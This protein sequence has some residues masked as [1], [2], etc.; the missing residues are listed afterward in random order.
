MLRVPHLAD[1]L[2]ENGGTGQ[3]KSHIADITFAWVSGKSI[4]EIAKSYF[5]GNETDS[6]T[7][8]CKAIYKNIVNTGTWGLS[9]LSRMAGLDFSNLS[10]SQRR[11]INV[12]PAMIYHGVQTEEAVL[13]RM[14]AAPRSVAENL[15]AEF[16]SNLG[17][18][19]SK[20]NASSARE[21]IK[22]L[23]DKD[24]DRIKPASS[25]LSGNDYKAI[26]ELLSGEQR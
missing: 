18:K 26:W 23:N 22:G 20:A 10:E 19:I 24:W 17:E 11:Q 2:S 3:I 21:F 12:L 9:A 16:R 15:G 25:T 13:M 4:Q 8:A 5:E 6:I 1:S 14:N 7:Q